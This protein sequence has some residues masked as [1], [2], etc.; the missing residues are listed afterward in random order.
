LNRVMLVITTE[1]VSV[2]VTKEIYVNMLD[3]VNNLNFQLYLCGSILCNFRAKLS[4]L[5]KKH[6]FYMCV[7]YAT[8]GAGPIKVTSNDCFLR[9]K[10]SNDL[11][12]ACVLKL[13]IRGER[14]YTRSMVECN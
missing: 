4:L 14:N 12:S 11:S 3:K 2:F 13:L 5:Y 6:S 7:Y 1:I 10:K 8:N 9:V